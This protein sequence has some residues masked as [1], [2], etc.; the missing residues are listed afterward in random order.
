MLLPPHRIGFAGEVAQGRDLLGR[1]EPEMVGMIA[2][3]KGLHPS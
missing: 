1:I 2:G 3:G